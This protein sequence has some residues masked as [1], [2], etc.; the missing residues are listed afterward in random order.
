[1]EYITP[2]LTFNNALIYSGFCT[3]AGAIYGCSLAYDSFMRTFNNKNYNIFNLLFRI[4]MGHEKDEADGIIP[5]AISGFFFSIFG[6][7]YG[8]VLLYKKLRGQ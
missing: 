4:I 2:F 5:G 1:M 3:F 7:I 6:V 8:P